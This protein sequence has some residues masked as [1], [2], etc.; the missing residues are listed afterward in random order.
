MSLS[1]TV[2]FKHENEEFEFKKE[3]IIFLKRYYREILNSKEVIFVTKAN[4]SQVQ[5]FFTFLR[6]G[7]VPIKYE[8]QIQV[9]QLLKESECHFSLFDSFRFR[10]QS[11]EA[12]G[13]IIYNNILFKVN[14]GCL[15]LH[16]SVFQ[17]F[18]SHHSEEV[19]SFVDTFSAKS[20]EVFLDFV[21]CRIDRPNLDE[22]DSVLDICR[23]LGCDT[24]CG[25]INESSVESIM[26]TILRKQGEDCFD[27]SF[28]EETICAN[29]EDF[30]DFPS[31][32]ELNIGFLSRI[33]QKSK[34][35]FCVSS[36][37]TFFEKCV[38]FH[39]SKASILLSVIQIEP[40]KHITDLQEF[41]SVFSGSERGDFYSS[42]LFLVNNFCEEFEEK[43][44]HIRNLEIRI[45]KDKQTIEGKREIIEIM[46]EKIQNRDET[47]SEMQTK[48][49]ILG[50]E[51]AS[52]KISQF[53]FEKRR[54]EEE[55]RK[56][57]EEEAERKRKEEE[58]RKRAEA[59]KI[60]EEEF[61]KFGQ[62]KSKKAPDFEGDLFVAAKE[63]KLTSV[64]Y[65]LAN[66]SS[67]NAK[68]PSN[69]GWRNTNSTP[70][71]YASTNGHL[72]VVEYLIKNGADINAKDKWG[73]TPLKLELKQ[74][75]KD[76]L[77]NHGG[78]E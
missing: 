68:D 27:Y 9:F 16:S 49:E 6:N 2:V 72:S 71:H 8:D 77:R 40:C 44:Q 52:L 20:F 38:S 4:H 35:V 78:R 54:H 57:I 42:H 21:H 10:I 37:R 5:S 13:Y 61:E 53:E 39:G 3:E 74:E 22:V 12:N 30:L 14:I 11:Q 63:G 75:I 29:L 58:N 1:E 48:I 70:L 67:V 17:R 43:V 62:W 65:L 31:F 19:F 55:T 59:D 15:Y 46:E 41:L 36:L 47:I 33:F 51:I 64:I 23:Y 60:K 25:L 73:R 26:S 7:C 69:S 45:E 34:R 24:L 66:N 76:L 32:S 18:Y 56:K 28:Y 50:K